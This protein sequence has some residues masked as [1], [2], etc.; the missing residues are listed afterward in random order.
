MAR[1]DDAAR[2][3]RRALARCRRARRAARRFP[4]RHVL[5]EGADGY[6]ALFDAAELDFGFTDR[7]VLLAERTD[8]TALNTKDRPV[9]LIVPDKKRPA[10]WVR[11]V[12]RI[13]IVQIPSTSP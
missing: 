13:R 11:Q 8:R 10:R 9:Q 6:R 12:R 2:T 1:P 4:A 7:I 5:I 3:G